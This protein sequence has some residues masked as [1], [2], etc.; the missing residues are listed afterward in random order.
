MAASGALLDTN[1]ASAQFAEPV[2]ITEG[3]GNVTESTMAFDL[4][5]NAYIVSV[6]DEKLRIDLVGPDLRASRELPGE[7]T[8]Q[9]Q[10]S[11][12]TGSVGDAFIAFAQNDTSEFGIGRDIYLTHNAGGRFT[13]PE[14]ISDS[15]LD[16]FTPCIAIDPGAEP[17]IAWVRSS[18][19]SEVGVVVYFDHAKNVRVDVAR[20]EFP[21]LWVG[22]DRT[23]HLLYAR[24]NDLYYT[25][26]KSGQFEGEERIVTTPTEPEFVPNISGSGS[27]TLVATYNSTG[28][29]YLVTKSGNQPFSPPRLVEA[30]GVLDP[31]SKSG[32]GA[33]ISITYAKDGDIYVL[34]GFAGVL[35]DTEPVVAG[36]EAVESKPQ[37]AVD[38]CGITHVSFLRDGDVF[39]TNNAG[40]VVPEFSADK[41]T[42]EVPLHVQFQDLSNGK[43]QSYRWDFGDGTTSSSPSPKHAYEEPGEYNVSLTVF[44]AN[45]EETVVREKFIVVQE[46]HNTMWIPSQR[47]YQGQE[48]VYFPVRG[49]HRD[50]VMAFQVHAVF[51]QNLLSVHD[52]T[53]DGTPV[54]SLQP[55]IWECNI[56]ARS[57]EIGCIFDF[58]PPFDGRAL[59][60]TNSGNTLVNMLFD[61]AEEAPAGAVTEI[62]LINNRAVS[63]IFN[64]FTVDNR[65]KLPVLTPARVEIVS[66]DAAEVAG[67]F[68]RGD[69]DGSGRVDISDG[70]GLLNFL[71]T[72][73][74]EPVCYDAADVKDEGAV[75]ISAAI[76]LLNFLFLGGKSLP[77]PYPNPGLDTIPGNDGWTCL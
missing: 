22:P 76:Y 1:S 3:F 34:R 77:P 27:S 62:E 16:E 4:A 64:V 52:C 17:H 7:A 63:Q 36:T 21:S 56:F 23:A 46:P 37:H 42:G 5:N 10:P 67:A 11:L 26:N 54:A 19:D 33:A 13:D 44:T 47:V 32:N 14:K 55:E 24:D 65:S 68:V 35:L 71:F 43:V 74:D 28:S 15:M 48:Q 50:E 72:G 29:L 69:V 9:S 45:R 75:D 12:V 61:V 38:V 20:G 8:G 73:G 53:R 39:Y 40:E 51:D 49:A 41:V 6:V 31:Q 30:G 18:G 59:P 58:V 2:R 57:V 25:N 66:R 60:P 70:I